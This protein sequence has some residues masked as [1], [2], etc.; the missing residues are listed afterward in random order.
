MDVSAIHGNGSAKHLNT[1]SS[2]NSL[3]NLR[4][5]NAWRKDEITRRITR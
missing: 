1:Y 5:A 3:S 4:S 2:I